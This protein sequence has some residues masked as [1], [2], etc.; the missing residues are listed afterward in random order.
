MVRTLGRDRAR[1]RLVQRVAERDRCPGT[2]GR[3][4]CAVSVTDT[5]I[6][7]SYTAD[8]MMTIES[9]ERIRTEIFIAEN[10]P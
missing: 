8:D 6:A 1:S 4:R 3:G 9:Q 5:A 2:G 10:L 7:P